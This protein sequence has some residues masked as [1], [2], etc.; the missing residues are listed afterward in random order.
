MAEINNFLELSYAAPKHL[1]R[2]IL[3]WLHQI[4]VLYRKLMQFHVR[5]CQAQGTVPG[6][7]WGGK[8]SHLSC[9]HVNLGGLAGAST[10]FSSLPAWVLPS[11]AAS[12]LHTP[13]HTQPQEF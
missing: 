3:E 9:P 5:S 1:S 7:Q 13:L 8:G 12:P 11:A 4:L 6:W 2:D 10:P